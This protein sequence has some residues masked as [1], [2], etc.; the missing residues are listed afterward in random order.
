MSRLEKCRHKIIPLR[1]FIR[2]SGGLFNRSHTPAAHLPPSFS[3]PHYIRRF[4]EPSSPSSLHNTLLHLQLGLSAP[5]FIRR[6]IQQQISLCSFPVSS[7]LCIVSHIITSSHAIKNV[8]KTTAGC[9][10]N[11][12]GRPVRET[13]NEVS[14][15]TPRSWCTCR[16]VSAE[17]T[18]DMC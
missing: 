13:R 7:S 18:W 10:A 2:P 15:C 3:T 6:L 12:A 4:P 5:L 9:H 1:T 8:R 17:Y 11:T 16:L 14:G